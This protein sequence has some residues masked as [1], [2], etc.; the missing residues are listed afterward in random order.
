MR[1]LIVKGKEFHAINVQAGADPAE[2]YAASEFIQ[3]MAKFGIPEGE[4][5]KVR[6]YLDSTAGR[7]GFRITV[8]DAD[9][10]EIAG[11]NGRGVNYGVYRFLERYAGV[12]Y[13]MPG[14]ETLG[15]GDIVVEEEYAHAPVFEL[16]QSD[17][18]CCRD[19]DWSVKN[20][21]N[22]MLSI[23]E[24]RGGC[25]RYAK[26]YWAHT[27]SKLAGTD[28]QPCVTDPEVLQKTI[29][30]VREVLRREPKDVI[31]SVTQDDGS[32][33]CTCDRCMKIVEE[34]ESWS[35]LYLR[36][37]NQVAEAVEEEF[38]DAVI[39]TFAYYYTEKAPKITR[40]R[41]N[42]CIRLCAYSTCHSHTVSDNG[43][44]GNI[45]FNKV[46]EDWFA[47]CDRIYIWEYTQNYHYYIPP[48]P[49][50]GVLR[51][52]MRYYA[53]HGAKGIYPEGNHNSPRYAGF[54]ELRCYLLARL[55]WDP[56]MSNQDYY[57]HMDEFL[58][59][60]YGKGWRYIRAYLDNLMGMIPAN[61]MGGIHPSEYLRRDMLEVL[62]DTFENWWNKAEELAGDRLEYVK[63]TRLQWEYL[64]LDLYPDEEK[65]RAFDKAV[66][67]NNIYW[68][69]DIRELLPE[70]PPERFAR[71]PY[72]W[73]WDKCD[74]FGTPV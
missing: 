8:S 29:A 1:K 70:N 37:V 4:G 31:I 25:F 22:D 26:G 49:D 62:A 45:K 15:E 71:S 59:A 65:G 28:K 57:G 72:T 2:Q 52:N 64:R 34:E 48:Y 44:P 18:R 3:Y 54:G 32:Y 27:M 6:I 74:P 66:R 39:D 17:W 35:G 33:R 14:L 42:V 50:F 63:R 40:P 47:I 19:V 16:R 24:E 30:S 9:T 21:V 60:Y 43:C 55:M 51:Q 38:P 61:C 5:L 20:G 67:E 73:Y 13:F 53:E 68:R 7:D 12:R 69:E 58:A 11:G 46:V 36:F 10:L 56:Y 23:P 41:H